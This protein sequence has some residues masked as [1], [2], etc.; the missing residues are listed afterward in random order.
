[1]G[2]VH[3]TLAIPGDRSDVAVAG[4][5]GAPGETQ[6]MFATADGRLF[7]TL[8]DANG[9][10]SGEGDISTQGDVST[11]VNMPGAL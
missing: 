6:F 7:H 3:S 9:K 2:N 5:G 10:W 8:R 4:T 11:Q 1:V